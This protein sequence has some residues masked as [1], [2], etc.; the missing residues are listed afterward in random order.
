M[1][2]SEACRA[3]SAMLP[4]QPPVSHDLELVVYEGA[5]S[6]DEELSGGELD[7]HEAQ[8]SG[9]DRELKDKL[10]RRFGGHIGTLKLEFSKKKKKGKLP[11]EARQTL[12]GWWD[13]HYK[14]PYPTVRISLSS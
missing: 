7:V 12:L 4:V 9:E 2:I 6:S 8:P 14:W 5:P 11:K 3:I 1:M 13:V 10:F